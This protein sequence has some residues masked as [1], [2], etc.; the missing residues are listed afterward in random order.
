[1][2]NVFLNLL[3][4]AVCGVGLWW[5]A[6]LVV[7]GSTNIAR[8]LGISNLAIGLTVIAFGTSAP[9][10]AVTAIAAIKGQGDISVSNV[11]G[12]NFLNLGL[13][14]GSVAL[15]RAIPTTQVKA[16][17]EGAIL[18]G[19]TLLFIM[20]MADFKMARWEGFLFLALLI[21]YIL[22]MFFSSSANQ[23]K[24]PEG[25]FKYL[26]VIKLIGGLVIILVSSNYLVEAAVVLARQIGISEWMIGETIVALGTSLPELATSLAAVIRGNYGLSIGNLIG[27]N[28]F[29]LFGVLGLAAILRPM[30]ID[31]DAFSHLI[32]LLAFMVLVVIFIRTNRK[33]SRLKGA[34]L[35]L[36]NAAVWVKGFLEH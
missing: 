27:S 9:E 14:L 26:D 28:L 16:R 10:F 7:D 6:N 13:V 18:I 32:W 11:V 12:S 8:K 5:S 19:G 24:I 1:M 2:I 36:I 35:I 22:Y 33:I 30:T 20:L 21:A 31:Q 29:N 25:E 4:I 17:R 15:F 34:V 3:I 23:E